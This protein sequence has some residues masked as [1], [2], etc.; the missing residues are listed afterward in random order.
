MYEYRCT[1]VKIIDGDT[2]DVDL[3]LGFSVIL[4]KQ[5]IR[6]YGINTPESASSLVKAGADYIVTG[7]QIENLPSSTELIK[8][9]QAVHQS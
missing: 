1:L 9:T 7:S 4:K 6:L 5:R 2:I 3:D 8:F